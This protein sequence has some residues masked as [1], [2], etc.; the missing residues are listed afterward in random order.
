MESYLSQMITQWHNLK[1]MQNYY[2]SERINTE[3]AI[4]QYLQD[5]EQWKDKGTI[6]FDNLRIRLKMNRKWDQ[7]QIALIKA[8]HHLCAT[9]FPFITEYKEVKTQSDYLAVKEPHI[10]QK[11]MPALLEYPAKPYFF[12]PEKG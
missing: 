4:Q 11:L 1:D 6:S 3:Q 2:Y 9:Q 8:Q 10:W 7:K 5:P 12:A